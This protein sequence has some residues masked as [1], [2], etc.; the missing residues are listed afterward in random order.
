MIEKRYQFRHPVSR[1]ALNMM[2]DAGLSLDEMKELDEQFIAGARKIFHP[3]VTDGSFRL[4]G[5]KICFFLKH[6]KGKTAEDV[7]RA[8]CRIE[9]HC[10]YCK[11]RRS[12]HRVVESK[13]EDGWTIRCPV[14]GKGDRDGMEARGV[15]NKGL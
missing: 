8:F 1:N 14:E 5:R 15:Q 9:G 10:Y 12:M 6:I 13:V 3:Y 2:I 7:Y 4:M 11:Q